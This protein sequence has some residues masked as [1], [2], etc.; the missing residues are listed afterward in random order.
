MASSSNLA[1]LQ[2]STRV[3]ATSR[4]PRLM[5]QPTCGSRASIRLPVVTGLP[6]LGETASARRA[7][8]ASLAKVVWHYSLCHTI[9][10]FRIFTAYELGRSRFQSRF[11]ARSEARQGADALAMR[12]PPQF[13]WRINAQFFI[14]ANSNMG[15]NVL[16]GHQSPR[17]WRQ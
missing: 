3:G 17:P 7:T 12:G 13:F 15:T 1:T 5:A 11:A 6:I 10:L 16:N 4:P 2:P 14:E 9:K 8:S